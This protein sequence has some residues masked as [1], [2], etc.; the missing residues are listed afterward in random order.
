[1]VV[2]TTAATP[3][4]WRVRKKDDALTLS[5]NEEARVTD[6]PGATE[7]ATATEDMAAVEDAVQL[8]AMWAVTALIALFVAATEM[9]PPAAMEKTGVDTRCRR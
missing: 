4:T 6:K 7:P 2:A 9:P 5:F 1:M 8:G 3:G